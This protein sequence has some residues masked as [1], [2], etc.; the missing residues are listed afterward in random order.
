V[1]LSCGNC[2]TIQSF[3]GDPPKCDVCG[4]VYDISDTPYW[5]NLRIQRH[6]PVSAEANEEKRIF[7]KLFGVVF[8]L[9]IFV[10]VWNF[11][12]TPEKERLANEYSVSQDKVFIEPKPHGCDFDDAPLGNKHCRYEKQVDVERACP[13]PDCKVTVVYVGW[14]KV[15]E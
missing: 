14:R 6:Q 15:E 13:G 11:W 7:S 5:Q 12:L 1:N 3:S 9:I 8:A 4:W 2:K 10:L